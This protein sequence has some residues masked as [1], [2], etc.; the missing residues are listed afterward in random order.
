MLSPR[1]PRVS[2]SPPGL[3]CPYFPSRPD[4][5]MHPGCEENCDVGGLPSPLECT[6][7]T[8]LRVHRML[9][10]STNLVS[11]GAHD[12]LKETFKSRHNMFRIDELSSRMSGRVDLHFLHLVTWLNTAILQADKA[13]MKYIKITVLNWLSKENCVW[14]DVHFY[15]FLTSVCSPA[16]CLCFIKKWDNLGK[17]FSSIPKV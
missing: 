11:P 10:I 4:P 16:R 13:L 2:T 5:L 8:V 17:S 12:M 3:C 6:R 15:L 1:C 14:W 9:L 7:N